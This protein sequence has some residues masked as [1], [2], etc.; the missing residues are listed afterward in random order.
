MGEYVKRHPNHHIRKA[1]LTWSAQNDRD[2]IKQSLQ[3]LVR[4]FYTVKQ[5]RE[6]IGY[7][8][9][10]DTERERSREDEP[11]SAR[12]ANVGEHSCARGHDAGEEEG[13]DTTKDGVRD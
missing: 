11:V 3:S 1:I 13:C 2:R 9:R 6:N 4:I 8:Q 5:M 7:K 10:P 12:P